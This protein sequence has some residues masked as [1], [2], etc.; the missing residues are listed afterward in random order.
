M[1]HVFSFYDIASIL[2]LFHAHK[3]IFVRKDLNKMIHNFVNFY[4]NA[5]SIRLTHFSRVRLIDACLKALSHLT[6]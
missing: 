6:G 3:I 4:F 1:T 5:H 2:T